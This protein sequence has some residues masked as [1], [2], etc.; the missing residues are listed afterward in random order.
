MQIINK[1]TL[2]ISVM[3]IAAVLTEDISWNN[4]LI[5]E[6]ADLLP[7]VLQHFP[8][9]AGKL[10]TVGVNVNKLRYMTR[11]EK[12]SVFT[13]GKLIVK[14]TEDWNEANASANIQK[15]EVPG[16]NRIHYV[17]KLAH[18][19]PYQE[20]TDEKPIDTLY[21]VIVQD[22]IPNLSLQGWEKDLANMLR[23]FLVEYNR[24]IN[25]EMATAEEYLPIFYEYRKNKTKTDIRTP[26][27][28]K[29]IK[30]IFQAVFNLYQ[31]HGVKVLDVQS[32]NLGKD[33][34]RN[35]VIFDLGVS[36]S[37]RIPIDII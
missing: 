18:E 34:S 26:G 7:T 37:P 24:E 9:L 16:V 20:E 2:M 15:L 6:G 28:S 36:E 11:G 33:L 29:L 17:A 32:G 25:W 31:R 23:N 14:I 12:G 22:P 19:I 13:D 8:A 21:Y 27:F 10:T 3:A 4:G 35:Y 30:Q 5:L 1:D